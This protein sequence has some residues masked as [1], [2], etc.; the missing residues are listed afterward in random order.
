[1]SAAPVI[2]ADA[3]ERGPYQSLR[4]LLALDTPPLA[5]LALAGA[6]VSWWNRWQP[7]LMHRAFVAGASLS[8]V[9]LATGLDSASVVAR[10]LEWAMVQTALD[11]GGRPALDAAEVAD[12][13]A[14]LD[15]G[16]DGDR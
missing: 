9:A 12:I 3:V 10:W 7:L 8:E 15:V 4:D 16:P 6:V 11:I 1:M 2:F 14:R 13:R 5:E